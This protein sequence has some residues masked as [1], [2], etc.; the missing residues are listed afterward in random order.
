MIEAMLVGGGARLRGSWCSA[1]AV[2]ARV[3]HSRSV[4]ALPRRADMAARRRRRDHRLL[5]YC[6]EVSCVTET[7]VTDTQCCL[8]GPAA[9]R[10][11]YEQAGSVNV[12]CAAVSSVL[13]H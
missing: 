1:P 11:W 6:S 10:P 2:T 9:N 12:A 5:H 7:S 13:L 4:T 3:P 8:Q